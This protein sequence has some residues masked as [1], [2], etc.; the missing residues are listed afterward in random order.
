MKHVA[1][2]A[3]ALALV[4]GQVVADEHDEMDR[5]EQERQAVLNDYGDF[6]PSQ[7]TIA[8]IQEVN[9]ALSIPVQQERFVAGSAFA[10]F[11]APGLGQFINQDRRSGALFAAADFAITAGTLAGAYFLLPDELRADELDYLDSTKTEIADTWEA[12]FTD[13]TVAES[14]PLVAVLSTGFVL[15]RILAGFSA[16]HAGRL[17]LSRI[18]AGE[19]EF[20]PRPELIMR[21][22]RFGIG[23]GFHY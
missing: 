12:A 22:G 11:I 17:A 9:G 1:I 8:E 20:E 5:F 6:V 13:I 23:I 14:L 15:D 18:E 16:R 19:I 2:L 21:H 10:S 3:C 4:A 7:M